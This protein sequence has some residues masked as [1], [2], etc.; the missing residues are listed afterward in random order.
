VFLSLVRAILVAAILFVCLAVALAVG[1]GLAELGYLGTCEAGTC[2]L[3][4]AVYVMP[5]GGVALYLI[6]LATWSVKARKAQ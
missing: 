5:F 1:L 4:A 2:Q 3:V 6:S